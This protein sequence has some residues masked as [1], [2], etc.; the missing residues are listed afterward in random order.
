MLY[1]L[2]ILGTFVFAVSGAFR[3]V[4]YELDILGVL[5]L[6][7]ATGVGG[8]IVRDVM[9]GYNP[10]AAF[11][12][13]T[14]LLTCFAG[15]LIVFLAARKIAPRWDIVIALD[16]LGLG[17]FAAIGAA[18]ASLFGMGTIGIIMMAAIT[19][20]GGGVIRDVL[21]REIPAVLKTDFYAMAAMIG[22]ACL[23]VVKHFGYGEH[24]QMLCAA[25]ATLTLRL[26]AMKFRIS[27]PKV[28][29]LTMSP[30]ELTRQRKT[31]KEEQQKRTESGTQ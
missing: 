1:I 18:K 8:G 2:D 27:L 16:A 19:A 4:K 15:G 24:T 22:G 21:V 30:S 20:T 28:K 25:A 3:A 5:V 14:Y 31:V 12:D 11:R 10:P 7:I 13:E 6:S 9:I 23:A 26:L 17:V 29:S